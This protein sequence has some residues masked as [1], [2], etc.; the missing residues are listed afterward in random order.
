MDV[1]LSD[2]YRLACV[3]SSVPAKHRPP[4]KVHIDTSGARAAHLIHK[5]VKTRRFVS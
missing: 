1:R 2:R 4:W 5:H 3:R